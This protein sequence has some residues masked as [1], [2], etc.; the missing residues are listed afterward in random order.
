MN[1]FSIQPLE[2]LLETVGA[3]VNAIV[4]QRELYLTDFDSYRRRIKACKE[5]ID[6]VNSTSPVNQ[7]KLDELQNELTKL[8]TKYANAERNYNETNMRA[9]VLL[10]DSRRKVLGYVEKHVVTS[11]TCQV[12]TLTLIRLCSFLAPSLGGIIPEC[13]KFI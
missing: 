8:Q 2:E 10:K 12:A 4:K 9:K 1:H 5:K 7:G 13:N 11:I 6:K 3:E